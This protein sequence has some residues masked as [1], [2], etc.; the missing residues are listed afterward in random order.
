MT[1][2]EKMFTVIKVK[3]NF[4]EKRK[5]KL[6]RAAGHEETVRRFIP[7]IQLNFQ[8]C[9]SF[10]QILLNKK[11]RKRLLTLVKSSDPAQS[12]LYGSK[13]NK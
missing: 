5:C 7:T 13:D 4:Q 12:A 1:M 2:V 8:A 6:L 9:Y 10:H 3:A 11:D